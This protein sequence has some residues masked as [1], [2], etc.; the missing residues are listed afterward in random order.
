HLERFMSRAE[1]NLVVEWVARLVLSYSVCESPDMQLSSRSD[2]RRLVRAR[3]L[4]GI[5][6]H[7]PLPIATR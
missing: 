2:A 5:S 6:Q 1:A 3:I 4:P 7:N